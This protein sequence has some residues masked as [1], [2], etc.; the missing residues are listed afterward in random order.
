MSRTQNIGLTVTEG[1]DCKSAPARVNLIFI[2]ILL[3]GCFPNI[4]PPERLYL[5]EI[6]DTSIK[7]EWFYYSLITSTTPDYIEITKGNVIDTI[8]LCNNVADLKFENNQIIIGFYGNPRCYCEPIEIPDSVMGYKI[9]VDTTHV[10][11]GLL[12]DPRDIYKKDKFGNKIYPPYYPGK[13]AN[14]DANVK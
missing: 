4:P 13:Q 9:V 2:I 3:Q 8:C 11:K 12:G 10:L 5:K 6:K 14:S 7:L 1:T